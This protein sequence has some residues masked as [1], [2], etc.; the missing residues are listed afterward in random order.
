MARKFTPYEINQLAKYGKQNINPGDIGEKPVEYITN[1]CEFFQRDFYVNS[2]VLIPR[3]ES[4]QIVSMAKDYA[5]SMFN[6]NE[7]IHIVDIACGS[8]CIGISLFLELKQIFKHLKLT[9]SDI[10]PDAVSVA[11]LNCQKLLPSNPSVLIVESDLLVNIPKSP[12]IDILLS[13]P[14]YIPTSRIPT[15]DESVKNYEPTL[16][17]DGGQEGSEIINHLLK[18]IPNH[19]S[20]NPLVIIE[21]DHEHTLSSFNIPKS[22]QAKIIPDYSGQNRFLILKK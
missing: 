15:L 12:K 10:S 20:T 22:F 6:P 14:P 18:E 19:T 16:A 9:L 5:L 11:K 4:E 21:I 7:E 13:N 3:I 17:L 2:K 1:H 8:G